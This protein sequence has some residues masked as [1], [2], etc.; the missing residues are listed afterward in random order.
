MR[1]QPRLAIAVMAALWIAP[2]LAVAATAP[3]AVKSFSAVGPTTLTTSAYVT[4]VAKVD[5]RYPDDERSGASI[6]RL[7]V[8]VF[9][10]DG[11]PAPD[12]AKVHVT[13]RSTKPRED[14]FC[15]PRPGEGTHEVDQADTDLTAKDGQVTYANTQDYCSGAYG[16][17]L[18][19]DQYTEPGKDGW[20][21]TK[22]AVTF[23]A[24]GAKSLV[25]TI[26]VPAFDTDYSGEPRPPEVRC[27]P[28]RGFNW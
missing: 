28:M 17:F 5:P 18:Y 20:P 22:W 3:R 26:N 2:G 25:Y 27:I 12:G 9:G 8:K 15:N 23:S 14:T 10:A 24:P 4:F 16:A 1:P 13:C 6:P 19:I 7:T 11:R 21:A